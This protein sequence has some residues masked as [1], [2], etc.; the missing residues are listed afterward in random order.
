MPEKSKVEN[1]EDPRLG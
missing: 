1:G